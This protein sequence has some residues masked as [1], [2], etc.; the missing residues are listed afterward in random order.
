MASRDGLLSAIPMH[1]IPEWSLLVKR[2]VIEADSGAESDRRA[3]GLKNLGRSV[4]VEIIDAANYE[5]TDEGFARLV[6]WMS[7]HGGQVD[8]RIDVGISNGVR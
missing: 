7:Q 5:S 8:T 6:N 4:F 2:T 1:K 3:N